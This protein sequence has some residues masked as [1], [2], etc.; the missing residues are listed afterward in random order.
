VTDRAVGR[1]AGRQVIRALGSIEVVFVAGV[2][3]R[4]SAVI[5]AIHMAL[6]TSK[7]GMHSGER[8]IRIACVIKLCTLPAHSRVTDGAVVR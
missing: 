4:G 2:A 1:K 7:A 8:I 6:I 5:L 3:S